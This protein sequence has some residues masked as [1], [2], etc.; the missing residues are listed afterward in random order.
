MTA[1]RKPRFYHPH[2]L[3]IGQVIILES[4][5]ATHVTRVLRMQIGDALI[6]FNNQ[7]GEYTGIIKHTKNKTEVE[8]SEYHERNCESP[9]H[10]HLGQSLTRNDRMDFIIQKA[11]ELGV[12]HI[13]PLM[14][15]RSMI[16]LDKKQLDKKMQHWSN[17]MISAAQQCGRTHLPILNLP[18]TLEKFLS[19]SF[20]G[21]N[22]GF[23]L[24][25]TASLKSITPAPQAIRLLIG[26]E[27]G[28]DEQE[29]KLATE[30]QFE[31]YTLGPRVLRAETASITAISAL[32]VLYGDL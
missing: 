28:F 4:E 25:A 31:F 21:A 24:R 23:D 11:T 12:Q 2:P 20:I 5:S 17:I 19:T 3:E 6:L 30:H 29:I 15:V 13:T 32:Q 14:T 10:L 1:P 9:L 18:L 22:I 16:K 26:P 8:I 7:G 27:S